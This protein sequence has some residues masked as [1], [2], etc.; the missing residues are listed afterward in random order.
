VDLQVARIIVSSG[1]RSSRELNDLLH[2]LKANC[3]PAEYESLK[4]A[5]ATAIAEIANATFKPAFAAYPALEAEVDAQIA[6]Y[7]RF[8]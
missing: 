4:R 8:A 2:V 3:D 7:G 1:F 5:I 6:K